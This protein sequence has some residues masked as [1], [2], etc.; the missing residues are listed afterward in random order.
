MYEIFKKLCDLHGITTYRFCKETGINASTIS[1]WKKKKSL[2]GPDLAKTVCNYFNVSHDYLMT[3]KEKSENG[4][5][6][7][8]IIDIAKDMEKY[9]KLLNSQEGK[10]LFNGKEIDE[11]TKELFLN[12]LEAALTNVAILR[13]NK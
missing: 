4:L 12:G 11:K 10:I 7:E 1:T 13:K 8:E 3:G 6:E 9:T 5:T 2:A